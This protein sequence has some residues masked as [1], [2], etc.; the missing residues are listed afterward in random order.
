MSQTTTSRG[1]LAV[2]D[3]DLGFDTLDGGTALHTALSLMFTQFADHLM[4]RYL[5]TTLANT[6]SATVT[7]NFGLNLTK[8]KVQIWESGVLRTDAQVASDYTIAE[9]GGSSTSAIVITN[10]SGG[11][12][13]FIAIVRGGKLGINSADF[14]AACSIDTTGNI[15]AA[16]LRTT[17]N[18]VVINHDAAGSGS[19]WTGTIRRPSSGMSG[20]AVWTMPT[21]TATIATLALAETL[22]SKTFTGVVSITLNASAAIDWAAGNVALGASIGANTLT[23]AGASSTVRV[24]GT[25]SIGTL[26]TDSDDLILNNDA[27]GSG[28]D[29]KLTLHR[30]TSGM[31]AAA[32]ITLPT[33]TST[34]ATLGLAETLAL[35]TLTGV[36][37]IT[38]AASGAIDWA[39]GNVSVGASIGAN[40]LTLAGATS[41]VRIPG[42]LS[43]AVLVTDSDDLVL[44]N[45]AASSGAD[46]KATVR[47]PSSGMIAAAVLTL[48]AS[49]GTLA[50]LARS[51]VFTAKDYDGGTASNTSRLTIPKD[52]K[53]NLDALTRKQATVVYASDT[54]QL[55]YDNGSTLLPVG[56]GSGGGGGGAWN[57][58]AGLAAELSEENGEKVYL[59]PDGADAKLVLWV[60]V[61]SGYVAGSQINMDIGI[62]SP[63]SSLTIKLLS[64]TYLVR[65]NTDA[66]TSTT[67]S[68]AST[69]SALTNT[70]AS[71]YRK[72]TLDL[73]SSTGQVN[74]VAVAADDLLRVELT[75]DYATDTDTADVRFLPSATSVRFS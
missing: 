27:A 36:V 9:S 7:H 22:S 55:F 65:A 66:V 69:N 15:R 74:S 58:P 72:T 33:A 63:S 20:A 29:W 51:E 42:T 48:P 50:T 64:T 2:A 13:T 32:T 4:E 41:T 70:V 67:N 54:N 59:Y 37:S 62:Y 34:L 39:A 28:V 23:L 19:D 5:S 12:K 68:R 11:S 47:R 56:S 30:P 45:D 73:T 53:T 49:T 43:G 3:P 61:P 17:G 46:W 35:K 1:R 16:E 10:A 25:L 40:T 21:A 14:D 26:A 38:L 24:P 18:D 71:Q 31:G 52:T 44:N 6:A 57:Q 60:R 75:R 8:L